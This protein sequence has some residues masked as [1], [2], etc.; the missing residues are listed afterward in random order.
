MPTITKICF[1]PDP[2]GVRVRIETNPPAV[3]RSAAAALAS[4]INSAGIK[5]KS[6]GVPVLDAAG[7]V[8]PGASLQD[9]IHALNAAGVSAAIDAAG[10]V[11]IIY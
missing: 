1:T 10:V 2:G 6:T 4:W 7:N 3:H 9:I 11:T 5:L 8:D